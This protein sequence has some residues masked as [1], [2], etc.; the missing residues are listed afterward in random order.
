MSRHRGCCAG[1]RALATASD[2][3]D[4]AALVRSVYDEFGFD[5]VEV[6]PLSESWRIE[7]DQPAY[8]VRLTAPELEA[9]LERA[10]R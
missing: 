7:R 2:H 1:R 10:E 8:I 5:T 4:A 3:A 9:A 6:W